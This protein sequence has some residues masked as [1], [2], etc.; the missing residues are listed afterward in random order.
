M[1]QNLIRTTILSNY[2]DTNTFSICD[3]Q[4]QL[5]VAIDSMVD[6]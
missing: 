6:A 3:K 1:N 2:Y 4:E 5:D